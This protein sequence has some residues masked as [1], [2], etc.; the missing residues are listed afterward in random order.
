[1]AQIA[2]RAGRNQKDG[3]FGTLGLSEDSGGFSEEEVDAIEDH[4]FRP[5]DS[6][7][8]EHQT[9]SARDDRQHR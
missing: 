4:R 9:A 1:M 8:G 2:G 3:T 7:Y 5:L 6:P